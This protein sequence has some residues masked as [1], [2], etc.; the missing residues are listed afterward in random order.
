MEANKENKVSKK[1][2][3][4]PMIWITILIVLVLFAILWQLNFTWY[5]KP[6]SANEF[7]DSFGMANALF[8]ALAFAFL[9]VTAIMQRKELELQREELTET[10]MELKKSAEAQNA[11]QKALNIQVRIMAKQAMLTSYTSLFQ[12][13][14]DTSS[15][16]LLMPQQRKDASINSQKNLALIKG[17]VEELEKEQELYTDPLLFE[18]IKQMFD[19]PTE[20]QKTGITK[21]KLL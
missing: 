7:G 8:S 5:E 1:P 16:T 19:Q 6:S 14:N 3:F 17:I 13:F 10:K 18:K 2:K 11:T 15:N 21:S 20:D 4:W 12:A 9:I